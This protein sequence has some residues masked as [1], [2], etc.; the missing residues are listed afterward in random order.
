MRNRCDY[1]PGMTISQTLLDRAGRDHVKS[2]N[3]R[4]PNLADIE[5]EHLWGGRLCLS[6]NGVSAWGQLDDGLYSA[7]CQNGLGTA[8]GTLSGIAAA[9]L[10]S[11]QETEN[12]KMFT[13]SAAPKRLPPEPLA[14]IGATARIRWGERSAGAEY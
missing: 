8:R 14:R 13:D 7:C 11:G 5:M 10:A 6:L 1:T 2:F 3:A 4:F 12:T 9:E